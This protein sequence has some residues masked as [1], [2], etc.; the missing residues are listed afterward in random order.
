MNKEIKGGLKTAILCVLLTMFF[1]FMDGQ[2]F[3]LIKALVVFLGAFA[4]YE[5]LGFMGKLLKKQFDS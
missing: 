1:D 3:S 5:A 2:G 4:A